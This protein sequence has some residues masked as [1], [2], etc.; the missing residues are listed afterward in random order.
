MVSNSS[1]FIPTLLRTHSFVFFAVY[2]TRRIFLS[3][4]SQRPQDVFLNSSW[5][6]SFHSRTWLQ[7][8]LALS[9]FFYNTNTN[10]NERHNWLQA[11]KPAAVPCCLSLTP[12]L[13]SAP[14]LRHRRANFPCT[15]ITAVSRKLLMHTHTHIH[16]TIIA[17]K[18]IT[19]HRRAAVN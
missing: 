6:S 1:F 11:W 4:S 15:Q 13:S 19:L 3:R 2:E 7:A 17:Y 9:F 10:T 16:V 12:H 8:T 5:V 18:H 14:L